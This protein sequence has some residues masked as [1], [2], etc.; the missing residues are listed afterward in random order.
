MLSKLV[1]IMQTQKFS[2][3]NTQLAGSLF[4][5]FPKSVFYIYVLTDCNR[6]QFRIGV[7]SDLSQFLNLIVQ[8]K[9]LAPTCGEPA[10]DKLVYLEANVP[11]KKAEL[12][13]NEI[14]S[15]TR[16]QKDRLIRGRNQDWKDMRPELSALL[17]E[18]RALV[19][20]SALVA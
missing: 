18:A 17:S 1:I 12:R 8:T 16:M 20:K 13:V 9:N 14:M 5:D 19:A 6:A 7:C 4:P 10:I 15:Y 2:F 3:N 11:I